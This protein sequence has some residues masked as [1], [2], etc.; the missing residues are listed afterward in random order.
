[1]PMTFWTWLTQS[2]AGLAARIAIGVLI[3][4]G[5]ALHD[6]RRNRERATRWREYLV[7][8]T[9]TLAAMAY[10][11][12]NDQVTSAISWEYFYYG[13][14]LD[15]VLGPGTPPDPVKLHL[16][17]AVVGIKA[18]WSAGLILGVALL[19]AN[20]PSKSFP[21]VSNTL[22]LQFLPL[23]LLITVTTA[24]VGGALG[25]AGFLTGFN[26]DFP[27][28]VRSNLWRPRR[29]MTAYGIHLGGYVG[30]VLAVIT[31]LMLVRRRRR[32]LTGT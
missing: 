32:R 13:K 11:A 3:F 16:H 2:G 21:R 27:E 5:L 28:L 23:I 4:A 31:A 8:L 7:L 1:M 17:A 25:Y 26:A 9:C 10:G 29:F 6:Y 12:L 15:R 14:E 30:G 18:T 20:N 22:L 24:A 19:L